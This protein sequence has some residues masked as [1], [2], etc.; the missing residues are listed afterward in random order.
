MAMVISVAAGV[1]RRRGGQ[2]INMNRELFTQCLDEARSST[3]Y[4]M[5]PRPIYQ[6]Q[7]GI[8]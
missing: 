8:I 5:T 7:E 4:L 6:Q 2:L 3:N 1:F